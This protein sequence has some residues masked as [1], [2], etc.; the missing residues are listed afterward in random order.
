MQSE[1]LELQFREWQQHP[2]T[3][4]LNKLVGARRQERLDAW[5]AG[6]YDASFSAEYIARNSLAKGYCNAM[7]EVKNLTL[8]DMQE[9]LDEE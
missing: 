3:L 5:E 7:N 1:E 8:T 6:D 2:V 4:L 9:F